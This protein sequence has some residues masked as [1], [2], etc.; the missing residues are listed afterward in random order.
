MEEELKL[1]TTV[2]NDVYF[3]LKKG[4]FMKNVFTPLLISLFLIHP[5][6]IAQLPPPVANDLLEE[7]RKLPP[8]PNLKLT[9]KRRSSKKHNQK[10]I[11]V[12]QSNSS[13]KISMVDAHPEDITNENFPDLVESFDYNNAEITQ[14]VEA[15][16]KLTGKNFILE[17]NVRG[18]VTIIAP[19]QITVAEAYRAFL[20]ALAINGFTVVP[21][22]KFLK[23]RQS[24]TASKDN[25]EIYSGSYFPNTDQL[26][27]RIFQLKHISAEDIKKHFRNLQSKDG[28]LEAYPPTNSLIVTD[29]GTSVERIASII[30][31]LD[32]AGFEK[33]IKVIPIKYAKA[34]DLAQLIEQIHNS[35]QNNRSRSF[36]PGIPRFNNKK[37]T[38]S[39]SSAFSTVLP[40]ERTNSIILV[41]N[42]KGIKKMHRLIKKLD[43]EIRPEDAGGV[44]VY[45]VKYAQAKKIADTLSGIAKD[46]ERAANRRSRS[47][48]GTGARRT[49]VRPGG[50]GG[51]LG[52][53]AAATNV[54]GGDVIVTADEDTNSLIITASR[55]DYQVVLNLLS[56]IDIPRDQVYVEAI[57]MELNAEKSQNWGISYY[58]FLK[59]TGGRVRAGFGG[60]NIGKLLDLGSTG[61][62]LGFG[63][64]DTVEID[65][66]IG[67]Q[68]QSVEIK[69]ITGFVDFL[70][71]HTNANV[72]STP[73]ILVLDNGEALIEVGDQVPI[74]KSSSSAVGVN[75]GFDYQNATIKLTIKPFI[76]PT[77]DAV[78][79]EVE[80]IVKQ[81]S[82]RLIEGSTGA[83]APVLT[84]RTLKSNVVV[85]DGD[86]AVLGG[87][88]R[89]ESSENASKVPI[90][91]DVPILGWFFKSK[92]VTKTKLNLLVFLTPKI[93]RNRGDHKNLLGNKLNERLDFIKSGYRGKDPYG[94]K[95]EQLTS[96]NTITPVPEQ[97][98]EGSALEEDTPLEDDTLFE[99][100]NLSEEDTPF[101]DD[102]P[103][104]EDTS[105]EDS[106]IE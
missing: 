95:V 92:Q 71:T 106:L 35:G 76:N 30:S 37:T 15:I 57:I 8:P 14:V 61:A 102:T 17:P 64:G 42:E 2:L 78:R 10:P 55:Q 70:K 18:T 1:L 75:A 104:E 59:D 12:A 87:L 34:R 22:G 26:I 6:A 97:E 28:E 86:T 77:S 54:F 24:K 41:G 105:F 3:E 88:I 99:E 96:S 20:S 100:D 36:R 94:K 56:K 49:G 65:V 68:I 13:S 27:T 73:Q 52:N 39:S 25:L 81:V 72:L 43:F 47:A 69:E 4:I 83:E 58:K 7:E 53:T 44:Y 84:E 63:S 80:Q 62:I 29:Y 51:G 82:D 85:S 46:V 93:I 101:E 9:P 91:G 103:F 89:D 16:S 98:D 23:I 32:V 60:G 74:E 19:S 11:I 48:G 38:S 40:D 67:N 45:Y 66:P 21:Y 33:Q 5:S 50:L 31:R 90:L 79:M